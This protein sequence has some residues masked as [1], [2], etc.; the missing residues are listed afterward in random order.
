MTGA[1]RASSHEAKCFATSW[2]G[3][4]DTW[5]RLLQG[6]GVDL[7]GGE[8]RAQ[9]CHFLSSMITSCSNVVVLVVST[10]D[11]DTLA[12]ELWLRAAELWLSTE[13]GDPGGADEAG[14]GVEPGL[15]V[16]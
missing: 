12:E 10:E 9:N 13:V 4:E 8:L 2:Q 15:Q 5:T 7:A 3:G 6:E 1:R 11:G 16:T 14:D